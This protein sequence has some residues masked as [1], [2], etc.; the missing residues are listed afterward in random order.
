MTNQVITRRHIV[1]AAIIVA[2]LATFATV[3]DPAA[4]VDNAPAA[5][6]IRPSW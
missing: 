1:G 2:G 4:G 6:W 5:D 3:G